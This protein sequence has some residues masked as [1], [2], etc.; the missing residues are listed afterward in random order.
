MITLSF[1]FRLI[2]KDNF[3]CANRSGRFFLSPKFKAF[4]EKCRWEARSQ[5]KGK[6]LTGDLRV[7]IVAY[8]TNKV[9]GDTQNLPK[10]VCDSL[11]KILF[12]NDRQI[13]QLTIT[14][15]E[16]SDKEMFKVNV[17]EIERLK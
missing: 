13:K 14:V 1:P 17:E 16:N 7:F 3:K 15:V 4:E 8:F 11:Q 12:S 9:H 5:Y 6:L 2:S 10:S